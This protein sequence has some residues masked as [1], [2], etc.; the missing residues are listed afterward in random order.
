MILD[1]LGLQ[2]RHGTADVSVSEDNRWGFGQV[3]AVILV[4]TPLLSFFEVAYGESTTSV[5]LRLND[6]DFALRC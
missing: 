3:M 4:I 6:I 5:L 2:Y 1:R